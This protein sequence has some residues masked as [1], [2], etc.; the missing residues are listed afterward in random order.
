MTASFFEILKFWFDD[1]NDQSKLEKNPIVK[2]WFAGGK[3]FD[4]EIKRKFET[5]LQKA[6]RGELSD[7]EQGPKGRLALVILFDQFSRNIYRRSPQMF[8]CDAM[9]L[10]LTLRTIHKK[11]DRELQ[12]VERAFLYMPLQ[13]SEDIE[14][15]K[16]SL[17]YFEKLVHLSKTKSPIN[18]AYYEHSF[19]YAKRHHDIV[20]DFGRFP[21]RNSILQRESTPE[22]TDFLKT[23]GSSF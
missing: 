1:L 3:D 11:I 7:W 20:A 17:T 22:E 23:P 5:D 18:T 6:F 10:N 8:A 12:L 9:A 13:H 14:M 21:H 19:S 2:K 4:D 16:M 15:Q